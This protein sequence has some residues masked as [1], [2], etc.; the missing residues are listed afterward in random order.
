VYPR[1]K[2]IKKIVEANLENIARKETDEKCG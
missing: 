2:T 1:T